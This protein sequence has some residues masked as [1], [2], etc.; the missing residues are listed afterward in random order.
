M[1]FLV[2]SSRASGTFIVYAPATSVASFHIPPL[3]G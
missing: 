1:I 2:P 3:G